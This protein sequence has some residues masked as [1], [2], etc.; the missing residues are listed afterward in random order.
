RKNVQEGLLSKEEL[1]AI[2]D[3][4][5]KKLVEDQKAAG[6]KGITDGEFRRGFWHLDL[7]EELN[8]IE[9]Y[10]A[11]SGYNQTFHGKAAPA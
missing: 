10:V 1:R 8:A 5:I 9:G 2:E 4:E 3:Q 7:L 6:I 11:E